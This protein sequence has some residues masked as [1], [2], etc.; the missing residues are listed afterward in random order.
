MSKD[1]KEGKVIFFCNGKKCCRY[2]EEAKTCFSEMIIENG[3]ENQMEI[4]TMKCQGM[5]KKA[6]IFY[7]PTPDVFKKEVSKKKAR[8]IFEKY[9]A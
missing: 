5:C 4:Q 3:L 9:I 2:N 6:P 7:L 1:K 8:K